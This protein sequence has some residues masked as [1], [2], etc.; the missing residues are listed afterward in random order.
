[1]DVWV[2]ALG[3]LGIV[4]N[5]IGIT[6]GISKA[7]ASVPIHVALVFY[8]LVVNYECKNILALGDN[9]RPDTYFSIGFGP[10]NSPHNPA[11]VWLVRAPTVPQVPGTKPGSA[12]VDAR[13]KRR[14]AGR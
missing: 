9:S 5:G 11:L 3:L 10:L 4:G 8:F 14:A 12:R 2:V 7:Y 1:M 6:V 13:Q